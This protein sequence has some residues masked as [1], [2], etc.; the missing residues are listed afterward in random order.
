ME[1]DSNTKT[2]ELCAK[3]VENLGLLS[4]EGFGLVLAV[5]DEVISLEN[6]CFFFDSLY[7]YAGH[8]KCHESIEG[9]H[10]C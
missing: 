3:V 1:V 8:V 2:R 10:L 7:Q 4:G 5:D 9:C 6:D